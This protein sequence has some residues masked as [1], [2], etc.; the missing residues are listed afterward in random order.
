[1]GLSRG[2]EARSSK[3]SLSAGEPQSELEHASP[4]AT[5]LE[6]QTV[7]VA[8]RLSLDWDLHP[9]CAATRA[10]QLALQCSEDH[11]RASVRGQNGY[12]HNLFMN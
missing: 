8:A 5:C 9:R 1:M 2:K 3:I 7:K 11:L 10:V 12:I 4:A 6:G